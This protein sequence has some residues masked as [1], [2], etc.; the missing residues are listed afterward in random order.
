MFRKLSV[1]SYLEVMKLPGV[2][3]PAVGVAVASLPIGA[4]SLAM[5]L[6]VKESIRGY[7]AAGVVVGALAMGTGLGILTQGR[8][9]DRF[10]QPRVLIT[11]V[12][13]QTPALLGFVLTLRA[14]GALWLPA[15]LAFVAGACEP[16]VGGALRALWPDL[17]PARLRPTAMAWSSLLLEAPV[18]A[19][20]LLL[21]PALAPVGA[22]GAVVCCGGCFAV[23]AL[24]LATSRPAR[25]WRAGPRG[26]VGLLGAL[27][28]PAVRLLT[29]VAAVVGAVAGF[30][31]FS[32]AALANAAGAPARATLLYAALSAGGLIGA[33]AYGAR[34]WPGS[35]TRRLALMLT[36]LTAATLATLAVAIAG[37]TAAPFA[38]TPRDLRGPAGV[39]AG[40]AGLGGGLLGCGLML[41]PLMVACFSMV[42]E[43]I[44]PGTEVGGF[45][46][47]TA[48]SL[49]ANAAATAVAGVLT[50]A[51]GPAAP[52]LVGGLVAITAATLLR[53]PG[54]RDHVEVQR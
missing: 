8:L 41:G 20:P 46:T 36:G 14:G 23:G 18:L 35:A 31:Q 53:M 4:L 6:L 7:A 51:G 25:S 48:A 1:V 52:L 45:T 10:G 37:L 15:L 22:A 9:M 17:A 26:E 12:L 30:T 21:A 42:A 40:L 44:P 28:S 2:A 47:L 33:A 39:T 5:L 50:D 49:A 16:Q 29:A 27:A 19:G 3:R 11:A 43:H 38:A 32:A 13:L 24:L 54:A 34:R